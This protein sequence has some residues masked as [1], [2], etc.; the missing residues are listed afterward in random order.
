MREQT[1]TRYRIQEKGHD[2]FNHKSSYWGGDEP[3]ELDGLAAAES[4]GQLFRLISDWYTFDQLSDDGEFEVVIFDG[5]YIQDLGDGV[6]VDPI[7]ELE[8]MTVHD[9]IRRYGANN[10]LDGQRYLKRINSL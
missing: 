4:P 10:G 1:I 7:R 9:F 6:L 5:V 8:R 3:E 2:I